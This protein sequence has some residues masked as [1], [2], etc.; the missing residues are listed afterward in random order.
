M[1]LVPILI[2]AL[3]LAPLASTP[4]A[5]DPGRGH[6]K[7][8]QV[9]HLDDRGH[10]GNNGLPIRRVADCPPGLAKRNPPCIPP[11]QVGKRYGTRVGDTLRIGDYVLIRDVDRY[12]LE[13]R[14][15]WNYYRDNGRIYRV[16]SGTRRILAVLNLIDA[17]SN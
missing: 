4:V 1:K 5:A 13:Q 10:R 2:A 12:G 9:R 14:R 17:F 8:G 3:T 6:G 15:G 7:G 11:G 16:D